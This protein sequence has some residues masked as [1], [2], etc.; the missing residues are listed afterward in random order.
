[1]FEATVVPFYFQYFAC[2]L[3]SP[4][5]IGND[6]NAFAITGKHGHLH[7]ENI[8]YALYFFGSAVVKTF[9]FAMET[10]VALYHGI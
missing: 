5:G 9:H 1:V 8:F 7:F 4:E 3:R 6:S 10:R 2:L